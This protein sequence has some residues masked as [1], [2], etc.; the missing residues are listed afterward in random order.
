[1][2]FNF[3]FWPNRKVP[4]INRWIHV[5]SLSGSP[6]QQEGERLKNFRINVRNCVKYKLFIYFLAWIRWTMFRSMNWIL[7]VNIFSR[8]LAEI[9][10][11]NA[12]HFCS[13]VEHVLCRSRRQH[14]I[15]YYK[16]SPIQFIY[17]GVYWNHWQHNCE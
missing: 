11:I 9:G 16:Q 4:T 2:N 8:N 15:M 17:I 6:F 7:T 13:T 1:M 10:F 3:F 5:I 14:F 12:S